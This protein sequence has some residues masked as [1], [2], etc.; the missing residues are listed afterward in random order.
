MSFRRVYERAYEK[1]F[2][3]ELKLNKLEKKI[4][5][6][7]KLR[8]SE[9]DGLI[10]KVSSWFI[11]RM[12]NLEKDNDIL[13]YALLDKTQ[14]LN[15]LNIN[16]LFQV[17]DKSNINEEFMSD[18][19]FR[20]EILRATQYKILSVLGKSKGPEYILVFEKAFSFPFDT[21]ARYASYDTGIYGEEY[22]RFLDVYTKIGGSSGVYVLKDYYSKDPSRKYNVEELSDII[23]E[24]RSYKNMQKQKKLDF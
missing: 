8:Q 2:N 12:S 16:G 17:L 23:D 3:V 9:I 11:S 15:Y 5:K 22:M 7:S 4:S 10:N 6:D 14:I 24:I 20:R 18:V 19:S 1:V 21:A 13:N